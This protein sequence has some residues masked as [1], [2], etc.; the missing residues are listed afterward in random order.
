MVA[1]RVIIATRQSPLALWQANFIRDELLRIHPYLN[2][3]LLPITTSGDRFMPEK[4]QDRGGKGLFVKEL[5]EAL[6]SKQADIAVHSMKDMPSTLPEGL[7]LAAISSRHNPY[8]AFVSNRYQSIAS[9]P[10]GAIV[11]TSSL[12][13]QSQLLSIRPDISIAAIRGNVNTR[14]E[15]LR[16]LNM[17][18]IILAVAGLERLQLHQYITAVLSE[19]EM[20]P[21]PGQGA[22]GLECR[23]DDSEIQRLISNLNDPITFKCVMIERLVN[24]LLGGSCHTPIGIFCKPIDQGFCLKVKVSSPDGKKFIF[25]MQEGSFGNGQQ[26]AQLSAE[27]LLTKG[28]GELLTNGH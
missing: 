21:A 27:N 20:I 24:E 23:I 11:G 18:A 14:L 10:Q 19:A 22:L 13:R 16:T 12:R 25:D 4:L 6:L 5:E 28:A 26:I 2:V 15:K 17:D 7:Q 9:L 3:A 8:D 1:K